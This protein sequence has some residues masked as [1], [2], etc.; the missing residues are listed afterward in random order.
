MNYSFI[1]LTSWVLDLL[2]VRTVVENDQA[3]SPL[4]QVH[5]VSQHCAKVILV[6]R[7]GNEV[8]IVYILSFL[9]RTVQLKLWT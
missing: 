8:R 9:V 7:D 5:H 4:K 3:D 2:P 1:G 6:V